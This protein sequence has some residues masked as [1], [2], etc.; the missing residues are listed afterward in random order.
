MDTAYS[1]RRCL[2]N[3]A[4][5]AEMDWLCKL[6]YPTGSVCGMREP[7]WYADAET[8]AANASFV[9]GLAGEVVELLDPGPGERILDL[10]CGDGTLAV[11]LAHYGC[12]VVAIDVDRTMVAA[13]R[14]R[15]I[16][17]FQQDARD[18]DLHQP[19]DATFSNAVLHWVPEHERVFQRV[20]NVTRSGGRFVAEFGGFGNL[21]A[22]RTAIQA[23][24]GDVPPWNFPTVETCREQLISAGWTVDHIGIHHRMT[25][26]P[27]GIRG[28]LI[29]FLGRQL[30]GDV[31]DEIETLLAPIL[32]DD[33]GTW[34][35]DYVRLR[36]RAQRT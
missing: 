23:V 5:S 2:G 10:G 29:T 7:T 15:G 20:R 32:L 33:S 28:W 11:E 14:A 8:Y 3:I 21:A 31:L 22:V 34:Y 9:S 12:H 26:L 1:K 27:T 13:T 36:F 30:D 18:L 4:L 6:R 35:A 19:V 16:R 25:E 24:L 17:A